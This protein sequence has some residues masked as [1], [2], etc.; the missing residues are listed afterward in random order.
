MSFVSVPAPITTRW[1][2]SS[3]KSRPGLWTR[4]SAGQHYVF[5]QSLKNDDPQLWAS[6]KAL[7]DLQG[8]GGAQAQAQQ[9]MEEALSMLNNI[10]TNE[11]VKEINFMNN[12]QKE[13]EK[14]L[15][16]LAKLRYGEG[17][18]YY[19][20]TRQINYVINGI[21]R[22][23]QIVE[24]ERQRELAQQKRV[25]GMSG[26]V[27]KT[28]TQ[29]L[30]SYADT[31]IKNFGSTSRGRIGKNTDIRNF[32]MNAV[33][34][35]L[36][37]NISNV[38][39]MDDL[40]A[41]FTTA[42]TLN[43]SAQQLTENGVFNPN[44]FINAVGYREM[45]DEMVEAFSGND[46]AHDKYI[47][48]ME[49]MFDR[50]GF[51]IDLGR[52][53]TSLAKRKSAQIIQMKQNLPNIVQD[54]MGQIRDITSKISITS[55]RGMGAEVLNTQLQEAVIRSLGKFA[56]STNIGKTQT[57]TDILTFATSLNVD[58]Q[59]SMDG[60]D[61][62]L[63]WV[64]KMVS[65]D[66]TQNYEDIS[67]ENENFIETYDNLRRELDRK[68]EE[69]GRLEQSFVL[70]TNVKDYQRYSRNGNHDKNNFTYGSFSGGQKWSLAQFIPFLTTLIDLGFR[71]QDVGLIEQS[72]LNCLP[73]TIMAS[74]KN[75]IEN[76]ISIFIAFT[77][78]SDSVTMA[79]EVARNIAN[80]TS[81]LNVLHLFLIN[82]VYV[83]ASVLMEKLYNEIQQVGAATSGSVKASIEGGLQTGEIYP[84]LS[85]MNAHGIDR[86]K[87]FRQAEYDRVFITV[88]FL[89]SFFDIIDNLSN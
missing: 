24:N 62:A 85:L 16:E 70:H 45:M 20:F 7:T 27:I 55:Q 25:S 65:Q 44:T 41:I 43:F 29:G 77:L 10:I 76:F 75:P 59:M 69:L 40:T 1:P 80:D 23:K 58:Y 9:R 71:T 30:K 66:I 42:F 18:D 61:S 54:F 60:I 28:T 64:D 11:R 13:N 22:T 12:F 48:K 26:K 49:E 74:N 81:S 17:F 56:Q 79:Q 52:G 53:S 35:E 78:F 6:V 86:W 51:R 83:P 57:K 33:Q 36:G 3:G 21:E 63:R 87:Q 8:E 38:K 32:I 82:N 50:Y 68:T 88:N 67:K 72:I 84:Y 46:A 47:Q 31:F 89:G 15:P 37:D 4:P 39:S 73:G 19:E 14:M 34:N 5:L 2:T